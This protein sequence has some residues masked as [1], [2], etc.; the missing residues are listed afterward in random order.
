VA[1]S[2]L[3]EH[4]HDPETVIG[5]RVRIA[6][7]NGYG[8]SSIRVIEPLRIYRGHNGCTYVRAWCYLRREERT[9]RLDRVR[10]WEPIGE[11][12]QRFSDSSSETRRAAQRERKCGDP[13]KIE[14]VGWSVLERKQSNYSGRCCEGRR[15]GRS[16]ASG[17]SSG[18]NT[19]A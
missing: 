16:K 4:T 19:A 1:V 18:P 13:G 6:Y 15:I 9:F 11:A 2:V 17:C 8:Q 14:R 10:S 3:Q 5:R 12:L 7:M